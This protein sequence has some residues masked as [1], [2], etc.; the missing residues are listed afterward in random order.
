VFEPSQAPE[1]AAASEE[2]SCRIAQPELTHV[3]QFV[4]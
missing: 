1:G 2:N 3:Q 4:H